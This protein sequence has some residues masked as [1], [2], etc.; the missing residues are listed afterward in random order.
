M[1]FL[2]KLNALYF[3]TKKDREIQDKPDAFWIFKIWSSHYKVMDNKNLM[4]ASL[5]FSVTDIWDETGYNRIHFN[6][7]TKV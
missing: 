1:I 3:D 7:I 4:H 6:I 5:R 2:I